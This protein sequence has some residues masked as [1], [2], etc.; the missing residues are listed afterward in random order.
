[1]TALLASAW[2]LPSLF[3]FA[4]LDGFVPP[5]PSEAAVVA[6]AGGGRW[7]PVVVVAI[8]AAGAFVGD[9]LAYAA[10]R[11]V[12]SRPAAAS[13]R[14]GRRV[15]RARAQMTSRG[16]PL[17]LAA[18]FV[19]GGRVVVSLSAGALRVPRSVF[20]AWTAA[21]ALLWATFYALVGSVADAWLGGRTWLAV[22]VGVTL[23]A[24]LGTVV[25][26]VLRRRGRPVVQQP[27]AGVAG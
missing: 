7:S 15:E 17:L 6:L 10:G 14:L 23:G 18:R 5:V 16:G 11:W 24:A 8:A 9:Q 4:V 26:R 19:P 2:V 27:P 13:S 20:A 25:D 1:M 21:G 12:S 3:L 22:V